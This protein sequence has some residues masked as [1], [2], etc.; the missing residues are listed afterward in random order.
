VNAATDILDVS[1]LCKRYPDTKDGAGAGIDQVSFRIDSGRFFTL[2][3]PSGC[4]KTTT[5][6]CLAGLEQPDAGV[7]RVGDT[8]FFNDANR[9]NVPLNER[10]IGMVFQS[11][12]IWPHM[13]VF[14]NVAFPLKVARD[15]SYGRD[16]IRR[17][18]GEALD[19]V[20]LGAFGDRSPTQM[21]GG[22]QQRVALA[23]AIVRRPRLLLLDEPLSNLDALLR[24]EMR[25]ELK[26]LQQQLGVTTVYVTH[27]QSEALEM[28]DTIAVL[29]HGHLVQ[30]GTA[31]DIYDRPRDA[32]VAGFMG[33]PNLLS[34]RTKQAVSGAT[35]AQVTLSDGHTLTAQF[36]YPVD[37]P[38]AI[39][40]SVRPESITLRSPTATREPQVNRLQGVVAD[41]AFLGHSYRYALKV[42]EL[43]LQCT[44]AA[45]TQ[46]AKGS[47]VALDFAFDQACALVPDSRGRSTIGPAP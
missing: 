19:T 41:S 24:E 31:Q 9:R 12:A 39:T 8:E 40:V 26:R 14:E 17:M 21:S 4:G 38:H 47:E 46:F 29:N 27:D 11:Y 20:N 25:R 43:T 22:Q 45:H 23:R 6:R 10:D 42:G 34:G 37:D 3:G 18:V 33:S 5:L 30:I 44:S 7:I 2:L 15:R 1:G 36:P 13:S 28:S 16:D 32:F 35:Q